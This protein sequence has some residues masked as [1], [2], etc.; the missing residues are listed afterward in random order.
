[1][2]NVLRAIKARIKFHWGFILRQPLYTAVQPSTKYP[3]LTS[4]IGALSYGLSKVKALPEVSVIDNHLY[5]TAIEFLKLSTWITYALHLPS[6]ELGVVE[7]R[8]INKVVLSLGIRRENI[9][10][11][12]RFIWGIQAHGKVYL[13]GVDMDICVF[14]RNE[15]ADIVFKASWLLS[16]LG[17][18]ESLVSV[19]N[20]R[21][22]DVK[23]I[24]MKNVKTRFITLS[25]TVEKVLEGIYDEVNMPCP[26]TEWWKLGVVKN[27]SRFLRKFLVPRTCIKV[28]VKEHKAHIFMDEEGDHYIV[29]AVSWLS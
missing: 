9:F 16:R 24:S 15:Y 4:I 23:E 17:S 14:T 10:P 13:P 3:T 28:Q 27:P 5:S 20:V 26:C 18:K 2:S 11:G 8:D 12:S 1:M 29:P 7:T 22:L 25:D 6:P 21:I 19:I